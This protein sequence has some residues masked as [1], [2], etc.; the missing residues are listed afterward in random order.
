MPRHNVGVKHESPDALWL[1][2]LSMR[3]DDIVPFAVGE[4]LESDDPLCHGLLGPFPFM[5][6]RAVSDITVT[7]KRLGRA[8][9]IEYFRCLHHPINIQRVFICKLQACAETFVE[10][11]NIGGDGA[12][13]KPALH[14]HGI[15]IGM[16]TIPE[17]SFRILLSFNVQRYFI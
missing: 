15:S 4:R 14:E 16:K 17:V 13:I 6:E 12:G 8:E 11:M 3:G 1:H 10:M 2:K 7:A 5:T 9:E